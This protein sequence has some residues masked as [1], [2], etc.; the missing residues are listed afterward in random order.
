MA[1]ANLN[2]MAWFPR[3]PVAVSASP[4][5]LSLGTLDASGEGVAIMCAAPKTG[6]I[7]KIICRT[8]TVTGAGTFT[9]RLKEIDR[10]ATPAIPHATNLS[11]VN[12]TGTQ[13]V[14]AS[15]DNTTFAVQ[16]TADAAVTQ[17][18]RLC[19]ELLITTIG[20]LSVLQ[21]AG[22]SDESTGMG[23]Q[24]PYSLINTSGSYAVTTIQLSVAFEYDDGTVVPTIGVYPPNGAITT[25]SAASGGT[26]DTFGQ[27]FQFPVPVAVGGF[28]LWADADDSF[29]VRMVTSAYHQGNATGILAS[30][31]VNVQD[32]STNTAGIIALPFPSNV[33]FSASTNYRLV[34]EPGATG[35]SIYDQAFGS[36]AQMDSSP[37]GRN[38]H[39]TTAKDPT[40]DGD[41]TNFNS[42]TFRQLYCGLLLKG[43]SDGTGGS[44]GG[45]RLVNGG[46]VN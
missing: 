14:I 13:A 16:M 46:L 28:W 25:T 36:L 41:W 38:F 17:G 35:I 18:D 33:E 43:F 8:V 37:M 40:A 6:N 5:L 34:I 23:G 15:D 11:H 27:R 39:L 31:T 29:T 32:R 42:G 22:L 9:A 21:F 2:G 7:R 24:Y 30:T 45:G 44:S 1:F 19:V 3:L 10:G 26:P 20:T 4:N 12:A